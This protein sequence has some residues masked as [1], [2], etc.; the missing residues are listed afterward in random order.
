M[1]VK[2]RTASHPGCLG[3][4]TSFLASVVCCPFSTLPHPR[5]SL[6]LKR[7]TT[8]QRPAWH[9]NSQPI[10][11]L[12]QAVLFLQRVAAFSLSIKHH[13]PRVKRLLHLQESLLLLLVPIS[14][15]QSAPFPAHLIRGREC[16]LLQ[17]F[18]GHLLLPGPHLATPGTA[19]CCLVFCLPGDRYQ[20]PNVASCS[21]QDGQMP[22]LC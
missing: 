19:S 17:T 15:K 22:L 2:A 8:P 14:H 11:G 21:L 6:P 18:P 7:R 4:W 3:L 13:L 9:R 5:L 1:E 20:F 10:C 12:M 16:H